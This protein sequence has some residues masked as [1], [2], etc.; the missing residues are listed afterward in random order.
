M[1]KQ[2]ILVPVDLSGATLQVCAA[3]RDL[4][5]ALDAR[6][7]LLHAVET[8]P[9]VGDYY[10]LSAFEAEALAT[11]TRRRVAERLDALGRWFKRRVP[12]TKT[13]LHAGA[14][15][16][17]IHRMAKLARPDYIVVGSHGH[18]AAYEMLVGSVAHALLRKAPCPVLVVP[19]APQR[20]RTA[21]P[22][23]PRASLAA[24]SR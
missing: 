6:V 1:K 21:K 12:D 15:V 20:G 10:A 19:V 9:R 18:S 22:P 11:N 2:K 4:A 23:R 13:I 14:V 3:A 5:L 16:A 17:T 8:D 24:P 7:M